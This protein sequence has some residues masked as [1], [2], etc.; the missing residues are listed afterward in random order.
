MARYQT[1]PIPKAGLVRIDLPAETLDAAEADLADLRLLDPA[2]NEVPFFIERMMPNRK[3]WR[4]RP[5]SRRQ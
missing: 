5:S 3:R 4:V 1:V 2:G